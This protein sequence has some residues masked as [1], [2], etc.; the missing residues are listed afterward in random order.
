M[1][2]FNRGLML[3]GTT[4]GLLLLFP[5]AVAQALAP[6]EVGLWALGGLTLVAAG[7]DM[8]LLP[9]RLPQNGRQVPSDIIVRADG[10]G[11]LQFGFEMGT[12]LRTYVPT[13][14]PYLLVASVLF[15]VPW[16][17]APLAG[18]AFGFGRTIMVHSAVR[19]GNAAT[20]DKAFAARRTPILGVCWAA[21]LV[22]LALIAWSAVQ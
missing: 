6:V 7:C 10:S 3:G 18:L 12:G 20:W 15:V 14:L 19:S 22:G 4:T 8:K 9:F 5:A 1:V 16:W 13:H 21:T 2:F 17:A 11:A